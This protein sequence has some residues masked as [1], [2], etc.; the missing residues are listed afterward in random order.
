MVKITCGDFVIA[1]AHSDMIA[2]MIDM[3]QFERISDGE[4]IKFKL[5]EVE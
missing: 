1:V 4:E 5:V 3:H 2:E